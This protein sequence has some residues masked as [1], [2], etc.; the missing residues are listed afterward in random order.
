MGNN[1]GK[2]IG[3]IGVITG[4]GYAIKKQKDNKNII[5][6]ALL[7]GAGGYLLGSALTKFYEGYY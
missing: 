2:L 1:A 6:Y 4:M 7:F 3:T 5:F